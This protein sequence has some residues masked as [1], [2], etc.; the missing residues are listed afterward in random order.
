MVV[1]WNSGD[2]VG[3]IR[4]DIPAFELPA[5][6]G[7]RYEVMAPDTL[8]LQERAEL[9]L[10]CMTEITNS[11]ADHEIYGIVFF[12][13]NPPQMQMDWGGPTVQ[14]KFMQGVP[15]MRIICGSEKNLEV[16][17]KWME[18]ALK[19]QGDDG[20]IHTPVE[21]RPWTHRRYSGINPPTN[22]QLLV[23]FTCGKMLSAMTVYALRDGGEV[24]RDATRRLVDGLNQLAVDAGDVAYFWPSIMD[25]YKS[26]PADD[27]RPT[28]EHHAGTG[29]PVPYGLL[30]AYRLLEYEPALPLVRKMITHYRRN[31]FAE[32]GAFLSGPGDL[33]HAHFHTHTAWLMTMLD[34]AKITADRELMDF[35]VRGYEWGRELG[36]NASVNPSRNSEWVKGYGILGYFPEVTNGFMWESSEICEVADM[37]TLALN[38]SE[39][40]AGDY[41]DDADRWI[42]NMFAEGQLTST[43]WIYRVQELGLEKPDVQHILPAEVDPYATTDMVPERN[44]GAFGGFSSANDWFPGNGTGIMHCCTANGSHAIYRIW[45]R[46]L[47][48][49]DG[50]LRVNLLL[51]RAS[52]WADID[53]YVPYL[54][55]VDVKVKKPLDLSVRIP[56]WVS[57]SEASCEVNGKERSLSW[58]GRYARIG[59]V[60]PGDVAT[61]SFPIFERTDSVYIEKERF[62]LVRKGNEVV[63]ISPPGRF[64]PLYQRRHYR[65]DTPRWR[66]VV[67]FVSDDVIDW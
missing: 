49:R 28:G 2:P 46:I 6:S 22:G 54:G 12:L 41:W 66:K 55:R 10:H 4:S 26:R 19:S 18:V 64:C 30:H 27:E 8:D 42:R 5:Y 53:S 50:E 60:I 36:V 62:T 13:C 38:L 1:N 33:I 11:A 65:Q 52:T 16:E 61:L 45:E 21:G 58:D 35:V 20:L 37:I 32:D 44:L 3:Y 29:F 57:P 15:L 14:V 43:D 56:E 24:W 48:Y 31:Y 59:S 40:G 34:Y 67:R 39:A 9:A 23:P 51:N 17:R 47:R 7:E 63:D 25:A